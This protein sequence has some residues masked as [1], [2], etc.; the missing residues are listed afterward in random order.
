[1][2]FFS[3]TD[4]VLQ[5]LNLSSELR[6]PQNNDSISAAI[7][8]RQE[9]RAFG[10][11]YSSLYV[12]GCESMQMSLCILYTVFHCDSNNDIRYARLCVLNPQQNRLQCSHITK[13]SS[14]YVEILNLQDFS[15]TCNY[16]GNFIVYHIPL[17]L[18]EKF[19][20]LKVLSL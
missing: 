4:D 1:M 19:H 16:I 6:L 8:P 7:Q 18:R 12:R 17:S 13:H 11:N 20:P 10:R 3:A 9:F 15:F 5:F 14:A 2:L